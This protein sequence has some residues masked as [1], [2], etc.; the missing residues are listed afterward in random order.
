MKDHLLFVSGCI[1]LGIIFT[2]LAFA[3]GCAPQMARSRIMVLESGMSSATIDQAVALLDEELSAAGLVSRGATTQLVAA[4][5]FILHVH[6]TPMHDESG[7]HTGSQQSKEIH[8]FAPPGTC[9][10]QTVFLHEVAHMLLR[11]VQFGAP[12]LTTAGFTNVGDGD[13]EH[14]ERAWWAA[15]QRANLRGLVATYSV[16]R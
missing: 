13:P 14:Q 16:Q 8:V 11:R 3:T 5:W 4:D 10:Y 7:W 12:R 6:D 1:L 15:V 9:I 2:L